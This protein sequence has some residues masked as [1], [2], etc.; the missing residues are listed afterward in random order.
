MKVGK[1][2]EMIGKKRGSF[3]FKES[4]RVSVCIDCFRLQVCEAQADPYH[5]VEIQFSF[6]AIENHREKHFGEA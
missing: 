5:R 6:T 4:A 2:Q 1:E 3:F